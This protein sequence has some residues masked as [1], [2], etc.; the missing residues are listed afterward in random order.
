MKTVRGLSGLVLGVSLAGTAL[1]QLAAAQD[2]KPVST[3][4]HAAEAREAKDANYEIRTFTLVNAVDERD[5]NDIQTALRQVII[6]ARL[7]AVPTEK[8]IVFSAS[9]SD[10]TA[11][12]KLITEL[13][14]PKK[15]YRLTYTI[16]DT[17]GGKRIG[18]Q[19]FAI[20]LIAG[21]KTDLKQGSKVPVATGSFDT[22]NAT[23][24]TNTQVQY[25][26]VGLEIE[27]YLEGAEDGVKLRSKIIQSSVADEH[28]SVGLPDPVIRQTA[29][30]G[31]ASL[32]PGK[33]LILGSIDIPGSTRHQDVEVVAELVK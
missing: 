31:T 13:D 25:L 15:V 23:H 11:A 17:D 24:P 16:T 28:S 26:D 1:P 29:L 30:E 4:A 33:P 18:T 20:I 27:A 19:H 8:K 14:Q 22:E 7:Y 3:E 2:A 10:L 9:P 6:H 32:T 5:F 21:G 12:Q